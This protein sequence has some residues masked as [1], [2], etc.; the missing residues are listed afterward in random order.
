MH[1]FAHRLGDGPC[2]GEE[3][4]LAVRACDMQHRRK[5]LLGVAERG[6]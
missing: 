3:G 5:L 4:T 6:Q 2:E 1:P